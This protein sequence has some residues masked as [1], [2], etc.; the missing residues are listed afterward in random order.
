M[1]FHYD[2]V[3]RHQKSVLHEHRHVRRRMDCGPGCYLATG[4]MEVAGDTVVREPDLHNTVA[5]LEVCLERWAG[6]SLEGKES[7]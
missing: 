3:Y 2:I 4:E 7:G 5:S 6:G 1:N